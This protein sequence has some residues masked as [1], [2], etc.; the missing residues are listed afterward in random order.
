MKA[1]L[2]LIVD[3]LVSLASDVFYDQSIFH[4][5]KAMSDWTH[6]LVEDDDGVK[7]GYVS[8]RPDAKPYWSTIEKRSNNWDLKFVE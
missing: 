4:D 2:F 6:L 7:T 3:G 5:V 8:A 1:Q